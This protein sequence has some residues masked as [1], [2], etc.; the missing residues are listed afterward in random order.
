M[1]KVKN[2]IKFPLQLD[3][4]N[5]IQANKTNTNQYHSEYNYEYELYGV[6]VH[7]GF[8]LNSGHYFSYVKGFDNKWYCMNDSYVTEEKVNVVLNQKPYILFYRK[9]EGKKEEKTV[10]NMESEG[11][12]R[13]FNRDS[14][15]EKDESL[16]KKDNNEDNVKENDFHMDLLDN[17]IYFNRKNVLKQHIKI[18]NSIQNQEFH[19]IKKEV[20]LKNQ[21]KPQN[22]KANSLVSTNDTT[23]SNKTSFYNNL[24][25]KNNIS[26]WN[27]D[28]DSD[29]NS[30]VDNKKIINFVNKNEVSFKKASL[31]YKDKYDID[32]DKGRL[33]KVKKK[34]KEI[35]KKLK[36]N[37]FHIVEKSK[38]IKNKRK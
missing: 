29:S 3:L 10:K 28:S 20:Q 25:G 14:K 8:C 22:P 38:Y 21:K 30:T 24:F 31:N 35:V 32:L 33:K 2:F 23:Q 11:K 27:N 7:E 9:R 16:I 19:Q 17:F 18:R 1:R 12:D 5:Y 15:K 13:Q 6:L 4:S 26:K 36:D 34:K 37:P